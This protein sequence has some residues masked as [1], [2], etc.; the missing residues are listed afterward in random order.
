[1]KIVRS[2]LDG[3]VCE[4][5]GRKT[6]AHLNMVAVFLKAFQLRG[7]PGGPV[8][9]VTNVKGNDSNLRMLQKLENDYCD[10]NV[11]DKYGDE[12][13]NRVSGNEVLVPPGVI[14]DEGIHA[15]DKH[16][17]RTKVI[18]RKFDKLG[19]FDLKV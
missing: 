15:V 6:P 10:I 16:L 19:T 11:D 9:T 2:V 8:P 7:E 18:R 1:M 5:L 3:N 13:N 14:E 12:N 4:M 17:Q